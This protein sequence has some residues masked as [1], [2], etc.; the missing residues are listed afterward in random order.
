MVLI[1]I[2]MIMPNQSVPNIVED[3]LLFP[4]LAEPE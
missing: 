1:L 2:Y 3:I 4:N